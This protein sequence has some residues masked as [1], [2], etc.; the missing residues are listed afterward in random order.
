MADAEDVL[1]ACPFCGSEQVSQGWSRHLPDMTFI[2]C[3]QCGAR[4]PTTRERDAI[5]QDTG[6]TLEASALW[7][8]RI[9]LSPDV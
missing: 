6:S 8:K 7:N 9:A 1:S 3:E 4:G 5:G 2:E